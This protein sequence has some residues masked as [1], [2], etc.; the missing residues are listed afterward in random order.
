VVDQLAGEY[1]GQPVVFLEQNVDNALG[2]RLNRWWAAFDWSRP[3]TLPLV[4]ASSGHRISNGRV[5][6]Y[7]T[8]KA[9]VEAELARPPQA[10][11]QA[12]YRRSG[13]KFQVEVR[14]KNLSGVTLSAS[15]NS[16][17]VHVLVYEETDVGLTGRFVRAAVS[18]GISPGLAH[19]ATASF[20]L[21]TPALSG[22][23]WARLHVI[24]LVDY[25]PAGMSGP[26]DMLQAA[27]A[28]LQTS[29]VVLPVVLK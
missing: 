9:M 3:T 16:A 25:R 19:G 23:N 2:S 27:N 22:V 12:T 14:V 4:M 8:Y 29:S 20:N 11:I 21:E 10:D 6:F 1:A 24:A 17:T 5:D 26:Y 13:S 18:T 7:N 15:A 28:K